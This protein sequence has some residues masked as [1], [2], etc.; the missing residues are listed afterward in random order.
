MASVFPTSSPSSPPESGIKQWT[1]QGKKNK[2]TA[3]GTTQWMPK[4][5]TDAEDGSAPRWRPENEFDPQVLLDVIKSRSSNSGAG[6]DGQRFSHLKSIVSTRIGREEFTEAL[7]SLWRKL[8]SAP[9]T[10]PPE[11]WTLW[12]QPSLIALGEKCRPGCIGMTWR[13]LI[14]A[15][16]IREWKPKLEEVFREADQFGVIQEGL[17]CPEW[18]L[19]KGLNGWRWKHSWFTRISIG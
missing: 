17:P 7:S 8:V 9:N 10:F 19:P 4:S 15:G 3:G 14:A 2:E 11:F 13:R 1:G 12:K 5:R 16:I 18:P 6:N